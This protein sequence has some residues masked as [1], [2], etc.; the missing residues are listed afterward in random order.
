M[1]TISSKDLTFKTILS[2][3]SLSTIPEEKTMSFNIETEMTSSF[4]I[5][6]TNSWAIIIENE[7]TQLNNIIT[8]Y[9]RLQTFVPTVCNWYQ[10][11][12]EFEDTEEYN[13]FE[14]DEDIEE[15]SQEDDCRCGVYNY[16]HSESLHC[17]EDTSS[18]LDINGNIV[19]Y[20]QDNLSEPEGCIPLC[21][22]CLSV[23]PD[24]ILLTS[25]RN[26]HY[27]CSECFYQEKMQKQ[28]QNAEYQRQQRTSH[29]ETPVC[30][31]QFECPCCHQEEQLDFNIQHDREYENFEIIQAYK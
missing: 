5:N 10:S 22:M 23:Q 28:R 6:S 3:K 27:L 26:D 29:N 7:K 21:S 20:G 11:N 18:F 9:N 14:D 15:Y 13:D 12:D 31:Y 8:E 30:R 17:E 19:R 1:N 2:N 25:C 16:R 4:N 24:N